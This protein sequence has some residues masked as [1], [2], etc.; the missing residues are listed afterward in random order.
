MVLCISSLAAAVFVWIFAR[1]GLSGNYRKMLGIGMAA[2]VLGIFA[3]MGGAADLKEGLLLQRNEYGEGDYEQRLILSV[4]GKE[5]IP[6]EL[7]GSRTASDNGTGAGIFECGGGRSRTGISGRNESV[8]HIERAVIVKDSYQEGSVSASW[9]FE[10]T[11]VIDLHG[12]V[13]AEELP[14]EGVPL[15]ARVTL[16]CGE[17]ERTEEFYFRVF[18]AERTEEEELLWQIGRELKRQGARAGETYLTLPQ[19]IEGKTLAWQTQK[20]HMPEKIFLFGVALA[21]FVPLLEHSRKREKEKKRE[22]LLALEYPEIISKLALLLG[23]GMTLKAALRKLAEA[24]EQHKGKQGTGYRPA[25]EEILTACREIENGMGEAAAYE[26]FGERCKNAEYRKLGT[27][28][29]QNLKKGSYSLSLLL[30]QEAEAAFEKRKAAARR[31]GEEAGTKLLFP[32]MLMLG[33][34]MIVLMVPAMLAFQM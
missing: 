21:V 2:A 18:P 16:V 11:D 9:S 8:N 30:D 7:H 3:G 17:S 28:L 1:K 25:Y 22:R 19:K 33:L 32:M 12:K 15:K 23:A 26:R 10:D 27:I 6:Y 31:Y 5:E 29:A 20:S 4:E 34:V 13:T 24:Y 14:A